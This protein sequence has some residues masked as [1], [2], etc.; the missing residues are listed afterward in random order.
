M[1][2]QEIEKRFEFEFTL[3]KFSKNKHSGSIPFYF[4]DKTL[5]KK[6]LKLLK[7]CKFKTFK[8]NEGFSVKFSENNFGLILLICL[9]DEYYIVD[10]IFD[11]LAI[12]NAKSVYD[13]INQI[14]EYIKGYQI[15]E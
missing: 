1:T 2:N 14:P 5:A 3:E 4:N 8:I 13:D 10:F 12:L 9:S 11:E 7:K 6:F 15:N